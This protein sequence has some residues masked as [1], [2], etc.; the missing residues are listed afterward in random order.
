[1]CVIVPLSSQK[2][3]STAALTEVGLHV[4]G[5]KEDEDPEVTE[6]GR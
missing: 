3:L 6:D 5:V 4:P 1:M 2:I